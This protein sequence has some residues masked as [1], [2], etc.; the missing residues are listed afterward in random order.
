MP[1]EELLVE[2]LLQ[3]KNSRSGYAGHV[4]RNLSELR[5][6]IG[7]GKLH[8]AQEQYRKLEAAFT[9]FEGAHRTLTD[10]MDDPEDRS[11]H[12]DHFT[13]TAALME[14]AYEDIRQLRYERETL[15]SK[16]SRRSRTSSVSQSSVMS[17]KIEAAAEAAALEAELK[18]LDLEHKQRAELARLETRKK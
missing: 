9:A 5:M 3:L 16:S 2:R 18:Y 10:L 15:R 7:E 8:E 17:K 1:Q 12:E 11:G 4:T 14:E 6:L 13:K